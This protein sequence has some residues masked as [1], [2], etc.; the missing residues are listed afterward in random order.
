MSSYQEVIAKIYSAVAKVTLENLECFDMVSVF[1]KLS[2]QVIYFLSITP[3]VNAPFSLH[4]YADL[5]VVCIDLIKGEQ[6][7][8]KAKRIFFAYLIANC[9]CAGEEKKAL[10]NKIDQIYLI[11]Y[12][13]METENLWR[14]M[15]TADGLN[16]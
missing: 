13:K 14:A 4:S 9:V 15:V 2:S 10:I 16:N 3:F 6:D 1:A 11:N 8:T 7:A 12:G 5:V